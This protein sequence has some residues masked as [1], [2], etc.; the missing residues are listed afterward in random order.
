M[1]DYMNEIRG[2]KSTSGDM[3]R[4]GREGERDGGERDREGDRRRAPE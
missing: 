4:R 1:N 3:K 2:R